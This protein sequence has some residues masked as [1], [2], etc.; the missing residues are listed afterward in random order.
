M[1]PR[2]V[3]AFTWQRVPQQRSREF[4]APQEKLTWPP[5]TQHEPP[6]D[7]TPAARPHKGSTVA[8]AQ[9]LKA[10]QTPQSFS[11]KILHRQSL[12]FAR[13]AKLCVGTHTLQ[14]TSNFQIAL[15]RS[16]GENLGS[17]ISK[18]C[19]Q[20]CRQ[21]VHWLLVAQQDA[22]CAPQLAKSNSKDGCVV[23]RDR[24]LLGAHR[25]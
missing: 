12:E 17:H 16:P 23:M 25:A 24:K 19:L 8:P 4:L 9:C 6:R 13:C 15:S 22:S 14:Q 1:I 18:Q 20:G 7:P 21:G 10:A 11:T 5:L 2:G 3:L